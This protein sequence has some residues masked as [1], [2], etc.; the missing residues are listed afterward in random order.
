[1][2]RDQIVVMPRA[3][4]LRRAKRALMQAHAIEVALVLPAQAPGLA[5]VAGLE[6]VLLWAQE[7]GR[8]LTLI[9]GSPTLRAEA[10]LR[11]LRVATDITT[12]EAWLADTT[13]H[14][15]SFTDSAAARLTWRVIRP[16][17][18]ADGDAFPDFVAALGMSAGMATDD[19]LTIPPDEC[20]EDAVIATLWDTGD[21][22]G[23]LPHISNG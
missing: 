19:A 8:A 17:S 13:R 12:W 11:G 6:K 7:C 22:T 9:G 10:V 14:A 1:M 3:R 18:R 5:A 16:S 2:F 15:P 20:F 4:C 21:F 23:P